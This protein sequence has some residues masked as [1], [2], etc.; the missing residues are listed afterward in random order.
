LALTGKVPELLLA[1]LEPVWRRVQPVQRIYAPN[2]DD[3]NEPEA[4]PRL[5]ALG[6][7]ATRPQEARVEGGTITWQERVLVVYSSSLAQPARGGVA[8]RLDRAERALLAP[9]V[10][11]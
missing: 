11:I 8:E 4:K 2:T 3:S 10:L 1:L 7:E 6:Y 9:Y 5:L